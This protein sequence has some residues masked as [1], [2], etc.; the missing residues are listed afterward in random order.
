MITGTTS[1]GFAF[2]LEDD[3]FD[4]YE[5]LEVLKEIDEGNEEHVVTM[6][7]ILLGEVQKKL[8]KEHVRNEKGKVSVTRIME[9][10]TEIFN[11]CNEGKN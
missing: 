11:L 1:T 8:L 6:V 3:V 5:L 2:E 10:V 9:E 4:D 7:D